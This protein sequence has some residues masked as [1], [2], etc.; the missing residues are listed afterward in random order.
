[1]LIKILPCLG[2]KGIAGASRVE[3]ERVV[4]FLGASIKV[5]FGYLLV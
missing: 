5:S 3:R 4:V 1:M 2:V